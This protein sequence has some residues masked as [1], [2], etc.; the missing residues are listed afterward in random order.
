MSPFQ[1]LPHSVTT[2]AGLGFR[3][4][5]GGGVVCYNK[6]LFSYNH[7]SHFQRNQRSLFTDIDLLK[8]L[9]KFYTDPPAFTAL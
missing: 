5:K 9:S 7:R 1:L 6:N 8:S 3:S 2:Y 4:R